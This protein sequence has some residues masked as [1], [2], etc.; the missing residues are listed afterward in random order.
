MQTLTMI[1][2]TD[3]EKATVP[4]STGNIQLWEYDGETRIA[5]MEIGIQMRANRHHN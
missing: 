3:E 5:S 1:K 4:F 2:I